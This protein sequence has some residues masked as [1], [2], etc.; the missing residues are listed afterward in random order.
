MQQ[1]EFTTMKYL[2]K[3]FLEHF[4][5]GLTIPFSIVWMLQQGI[6]LPGVGIVQSVIFLST[7]LLEVPTGVIA[8]RF[9]RKK[10]LILGTLGHTVGIVLFFLSQSFFGFILSAICTGAAWALI[11]GAEETYLYDTISSK[12]GWSFKKLL[13]RVTISDEVATLLGMLAGSILTAWFTLQL[14]FVVAS[15]FMLI[16]V[17]FLFLFLPADQNNFD[18]DDVVGHNPQDLNTLIQ[19]YRGYLPTFIALGILF[20][21]ARILWQPALI[22]QGWQVAQLGLIFAGLKIFSLLG[23]FIAERSNVTHTTTIVVA[24][25]MGGVA[26]LGLSTSHLWLGIIGLAIYFVMENI[27]RIN[28]SALLLEIAPNKREKTA[29]LSSA[30][31]VRNLFSSAASPLLGWGAANSMRMVLLGLLGV[32]LL[33]SFILQKKI[34]HE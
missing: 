14:T 22:M 1:I 33:S 5:F 19:K 18:I 6:T 9:G 26:L 28:Q 31:L 23:S 8:D 13:A 10:S 12:T 17:I 21:S 7:F 20:E 15:F 29:F 27:L 3:V 32:K 34:H 16:T 25:L 2:I 4:A 30:N 11:S 24:G